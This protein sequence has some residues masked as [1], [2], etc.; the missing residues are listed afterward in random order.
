MIDAQ[1]RYQR[2]ERTGVVV[3]QSFQARNE[4]ID[5]GGRARQQL[6]DQ[7]GGEFA[8]QFEAAAEL[9]GAGTDARREAVAFGD[10]RQREIDEGAFADAVRRRERARSRLRRGSRDRAACSAS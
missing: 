9:V 6:P 8:Q 7:R 10:A 5:V 3:R 1:F 4:C 2:D